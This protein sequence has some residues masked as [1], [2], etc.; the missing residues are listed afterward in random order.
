[1][2]IIHCNFYAQTLQNSTSVTVYLP[3]AKNADRG[4]MTLDEAYSKRPVKILYLLHGLHGSDTDWIRKTNVER[5]A[6]EAGV[7]L[8]LPSVQHSFYCDMD[9]GLLYQ[10]FITE[11]LPRFIRFAFSLSSKRENTYIAGCSMGGYGAMKMAL[12]RPEQYA[13]AFSFSG[14]L[15][16]EAICNLGGSSQ[17]E[18]LS[19]VFGKPEERTGGENDL[20]ALAQKN[21]ANNLPKLFFSCGSEDRLCY[22]MN[23]DFKAHLEQLAIPYQYEEA[24]VGHSWEFWDEQVKKAMQTISQA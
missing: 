13:A 6:E 23:V 10:Q 2:P 4:F 9:C 16:M 7:A 5:Y 14:A 19:H 18:A 8:V 22:Q 1:M 21:K 3:L 15:S 24:P 11:E 12:L 20:F 17:Q